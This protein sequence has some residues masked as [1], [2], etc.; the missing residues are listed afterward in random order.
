MRRLAV[1]MAAVAVMGAGSVSRA[2]QPTTGA[3]MYGA[4]CAAC[5]GP[6]GKGRFAERPVKTDPL[7]F[8]N[9]RQASAE[10]DAD[11]T[12]VIA[13]G[14]PAA[15]LSSEM[16]E[17]SMLN[18]S[19]IGA[20][21]RRLRAF[22]SDARW[23]TGNFAFPRAL[24]TTKALPEDE[25]VIRPMVSHGEFAK[26][27]SRIAAA[28]E[29]RLAPRT[30]IEVSLPFESVEGPVGQH[31]AIGDITVAVSHVLTAPSPDRGIATVGVEASLQTG[32]LRWSFGEG[33]TVI[34]PF[35]AAGRRAGPWYMQG[36]VRA[37]L[38]IHRFP[39]E[40]VRYVGYNFSMLTAFGADVPNWGA[41]VEINGI[42]RIVGFAPQ[43]SKRL[44]ASGALTAGFG[45]RIPITPAYP[46]AV[47]VTRWTGYLVWDFR[48]PIRS[49]K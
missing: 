24:F 5:H 2:Q 47:D 35:L 19:Q 36:D 10:S 15:G 4:W 9:C 1:S 12:R 28:Y 21:V 3:E 11:W 22:C 8:T 25:V 20:L 32:S 37:I 14:G 46:K 27:R 44:T 16:P 33:T 13:R 40:P 39:N 29:M 17:F 26:M 45:V 49:R 34:E 7:D 48:E 38:P 41:G 42:D 18:E 31:T 23:P 6:D 43:I 30:G